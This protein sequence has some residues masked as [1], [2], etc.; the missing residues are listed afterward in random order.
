MTETIINIYFLITTTLAM[1]LLIWSFMPGG[2]AGANLKTERGIKRKI[3]KNSV[4]ITSLL[5][6]FFLIFAYNQHMINLYSF[7]FSVTDFLITLGFLQKETE[8]IIY[9]AFVF[10]DF[11]AVQ[12]SFFLLYYCTPYLILAKFFI[13]DEK[14]YN[15]MFGTINRGVINF[16]FKNKL[17]IKAITKDA[18]ES[19]KK[20]KED[21]KKDVPNFYTAR[22][23]LT[24]NNIPFFID[25]ETKGIVFFGGA[26]SGK[27]LGIFEYVSSIMNWSKANKVGFTWIVYDMKHDFYIKMFRKGKDV[28]LFPKHADT[29]RWNLFR[30]FNDIT[31]DEDGNKIW[32]LNMGALIQI[33]NYWIVTN[34]KDTTWTEKGKKAL[35][36]VLITVSKLY[37]NPSFKDLIDF[38]MMYN[39][40][41]KIVEK[42]L[43]CG[44]ANGE[45]YN[46]GAI[47]GETEAGSNVYEIFEQAITELR[48]KDLYY[49]DEESDFS[50]KE[51]NK[52]LKNITQKDVETKSIKER[53]MD[54]R[55]FLVQDQ[56]NDKIFSTM[57]RIII[58]LQAKTLLSFEQDLER[59]VFFLVDE[60]ASLGKMPCLLD[61][62]PQKGRSKG[63]ALIIG[64]QT[65]ASFNEEYG[66]SIAQSIL[67]NI[68]TKVVMAVQDLPTQEYFKK[69]LDTA[70][71]ERNNVS[72][73][74]KDAGGSVSLTIESRDILK[75]S[76]LAGLPTNSGYIK[77]GN[78]LTILRFRILKINNLTS[79]KEN[80]TIPEEFRTNFGEQ[81]E[82]NLASRRAELIN[83]ILK[84][85]TE[86]NKEIKPDTINVYLK[87]GLDTANRILQI[88]KDEQIQ[89]KSAIK[90]L[91]KIE[92]LDYNELNLKDLKEKTGLD[93]D[94][95]QLHWKIIKL[96]ETEEI[97]RVLKVIEKAKAEG[98]LKA[99]PKIGE[100]ISFLVSYT[101][102]TESVVREAV[103]KIEKNI[104]Y[105]EELHFEFQKKSNVIEGK[106][107]EEDVLKVIETPKVE[108]IS[109]EITT[110][111]V[112]DVKKEDIKNRFSLIGKNK[113][114]EEMKQPVI[115]E[116]VIK[117]NI[118]NGPDEDLDTDAETVQF[119][120]EL[121]ARA[122]E[123]HIEEEHDL[124]AGFVPTPTEISPY[125]D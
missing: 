90:E 29:A 1:G 19:A 120:K 46:I 65:I 104:R 14:I 110:P 109:K 97:E 44:F 21:I 84:I 15:Q 7:K 105:P 93:Y 4:A 51:F 32:K 17:F 25:L 36:A 41:D 99:D 113:K 66:E 34:A 50:V 89:V 103:K 55:M 48:L 49:S 92:G 115:K 68:K 6:P 9:H 82:E 42:V 63:G 35:I 57:F 74:D 95:L 61:E 12:T 114:L 67:A 107:V 70:E 16:A 86:T 94:A 87:K 118:M 77:I 76:E 117:G 22:I 59:R 75:S 27:T 96:E 79:F 100:K 121:S 119:L 45:G 18:K 125:G 23:F 31:I 47:F 123:D 53:N 83:I 39:T 116:E 64:V 24:K 13:T 81:D 43:E 98:T 108:N 111:K 54:K 52:P 37:P 80:L 28:L 60:A 3:L 69:M 112:E 71:Y 88:V 56:E 101:E 73:N 106:I 26:G 30:E 8:G 10:F 122:R 85:K 33:V 58:E 78:Y 124:N 62:I 11:L 91:M 2:L 20:I 72:T 40:K 5:P 102:L 38:T